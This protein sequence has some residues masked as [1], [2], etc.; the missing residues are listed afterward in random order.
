MASKAKT[1]GRRSAPPRESEARQRSRTDAQAKTGR[2]KTSSEIG[3]E[4]ETDKRSIAEHSEHPE[5]PND[6]TV[7]H[8]VGTNAAGEEGQKGFP[9]GEYD[10][11]PPAKEGRKTGAEGAIE[12][13]IGNADVEQIQKALKAP[14]ANR[15]T[16]EKRALALET[17]PIGS[18]LEH[19]GA[20][21]WRVRGPISG[22]IRWGHGATAQEAIESYVLGLAVQ[23]S[24]AAGAQAFHELTPKLQKEITERDRKAAERVGQSPDGTP[25]AI[26]RR[27]YIENQRAARNAKPAAANASTDGPEIA[28]AQLEAGQKR[29]AARKRTGATK[30]S[31]RKR[32]GSKR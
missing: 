12:Q 23:D 24:A 22:G 20:N 15:L 6:S 1:A 14:Q 29:A 5:N 27:E 16:A 32:S 10:V 31:G 7:R 21:R 3:T 2:A 11:T 25:E 28:S 9:Q 13:H 30:R 17:L 19:E 8:A 18:I 4:S 26:A